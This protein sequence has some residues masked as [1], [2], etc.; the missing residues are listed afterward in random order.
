MS[1]EVDVAADTRSVRNEVASRAK[2]RVPAWGRQWDILPLGT[3]CQEFSVGVSLAPARGQNQALNVALSLFKDLFFRLTLIVFSR[4]L[5][6]VRLNIAVQTSLLH[7]TAGYLAEFA[8]LWS[9]TPVLVLID[10][11]RR[12]EAFVRRW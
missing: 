8:A 6:H 4:C 1:L 9:A 3:A 12:A 7:L 5:I 10:P 11:E 2:R